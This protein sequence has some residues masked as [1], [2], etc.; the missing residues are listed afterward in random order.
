MCYVNHCFNLAAFSKLFLGMTHKSCSL[1]Y[2]RN[3]SDTPLKA[4]DYVVLL[5]Q[6]KVILSR[7]PLILFL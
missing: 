6:Y 7:V 2:D 5:G 3:F 1:D 4:T